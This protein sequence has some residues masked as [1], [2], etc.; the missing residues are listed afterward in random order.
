MVGHMPLEHGIGVRVPARPFGTEWKTDG[1]GLEKLL[2][3]FMSLAKIKSQKGIL[4]MS[5]FI[6]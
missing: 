3:I 5:I 2:R 6:L 1:Q 4:F